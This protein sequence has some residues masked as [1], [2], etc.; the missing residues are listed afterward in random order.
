MKTKPPKRK[1]P[2][3]GQLRAWLKSKG[4]AAAKADKITSVEDVVKLHGK[5]KNN[6]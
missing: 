4:H 3:I 5:E 6:V 2:T 1:P